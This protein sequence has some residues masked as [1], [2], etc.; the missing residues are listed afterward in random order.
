MSEPTFRMPEHAVHVSARIRDVP[1]SKRNVPTCTPCWSKRTSCVPEHRS[2]PPERAFRMS[3]GTFQL[4]AARN[5]CRRAS[6]PSFKWTLVP[7][8]WTARVPTHASLRAIEYQIV[9]S[10][11][12]WIVSSHTPN[13]WL[14]LK[15]TCSHVVSCHVRY[16]PVAL[17]C[18]WLLRYSPLQNTAGFAAASERSSP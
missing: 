11:A 9:N 15:S 13:A 18:A 3:A 17:L 16:P 6:R 2:R 5:W 4:S 7:V 8:K 10:F 1:E 14:S 12:R